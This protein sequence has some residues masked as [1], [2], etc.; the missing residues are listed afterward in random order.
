MWLVAK[1]SLIAHLPR[2]GLAIAGVALALSFVCATN[3]IAATVDHSTELTFGESHERI[4]LVVQGRF[5]SSSSLQGALGQQRSTVDASLVDDLEGVAGVRAVEGVVQEPVTILRSDGSSVG[6]SAFPPTFA[7]SW[8]T[9]DELN[10]WSLV[11][12]SPPRDTADVVLD[13]RTAERAG[14]TVGDGIVIVGADGVSHDFE[15]VG[16]AAFGESGSFSAAYVA[17]V[18]PTAA[19]ELFLRPGEFSWIAVVAEPGTD[20]GDVRESVAE[21]AKSRGKVIAGEAFAWRARSTVGEYLDLLRRFL[22]SFAYLALLVGV[23]T[24]FNTFSIL[25]TQRRREI[26]LLR[27]I[28]ATRRQVLGFVL[29]EA[30]AIGLIAAGL[31]VG[32]GMIVASAARS[33]LVSRG[34]I[35]PGVDLQ[36]T[37][38]TLIAVV[39]LGAMVTV[40]AAVGPA[41]RA[42]RTAP[43]ESLRESANVTVTDAKARVAFGV[44]AAAWSAYQVTMALQ[45]TGDE[46]LSRAI[47]G[48]ASALIAMALLAP[49]Y[50][51]VAA[52]AVGGMLARGGGEAGRLAVANSVRN[53]VRTGRVGASLIVGVALVSMFSVM[54]SSIAGATRT[55]VAG[56]LPAGLVVTSTAGSQGAV[57]DDVEHELTNLSGV[58][59]V[60]GFRFTGGELNNVAIR[61]VGLDLTALVDLLALRVVDGSLD[62]L[63]ADAVVVEADAAAQHGW[64]VGSEVRGE[65]IQSG[66]VNMEIGAIVDGTAPFGSAT[67]TAIPNV[68]MAKP[69]FDA[70]VQPSAQADS[71]VFVRIAT[72]ASTAEEHEAVDDVVGE[73]PLLRVDTLDGFAQHQAEA[74]DAFLDV[75]TTLLLMAVVIALLGVANTLVLALHERISEI[76]MLRAVG[77]Q[78]REVAAM[79]LYEAVTIGAVGAGIGAV[80]G[81]GFGWVLT[82]VTAGATPMSVVIPWTRLALIVVGAIA[83]SSIVSAIPALRASRLN[84]LLA[85]AA[86]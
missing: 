6:S 18:A 24:A 69:T 12:G 79:I 29:I 17:L 32:G 3:V 63:D 7:M 19:Q 52:A 1:R 71:I 50:W 16:I 77:M 80:A 15:V 62:D 37:A 51:R 68:F 21:A 4:D 73:Y 75:V 74:A 31:G 43:I 46:S 5:G 13:S 35:A 40:L 70:Q 56:T 86:D 42:S 23:Y 49:L 11:A 25:Y 54:I 82:T 58:A 81:I 38:S 36:V 72:S 55:R 30:T 83:G 76:G 84:V 28:G 34:Y 48:L 59:S 60:D 22:L 47:G 14:A 39:L 64:H 9:V 33:E 61:G 20:R 45:A 66:Y 8:P 26:A 65:F 78:R 27:A 41:R 57:P 44:A 2:Y 85:V 53:P 67:G 10:G